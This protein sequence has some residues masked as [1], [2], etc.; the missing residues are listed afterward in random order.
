MSLAKSGS[1]GLRPPKPCSRQ[2]Q[3]SFQWAYPRRAAALTAAVEESRLK[4]ERKFT[5]LQGQY[6]AF[7]QMYT[8]LHRRPPAEA[9]MQWFF[10]VTPPSVHNMVLTLEARGLIERVPGKPRSIRVLIPK[11]ELPALEQPPLRGM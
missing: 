10:Q 11:E 5:A 9:D 8:L 2:T 7:I 4:D 3:P 1:R 6:L